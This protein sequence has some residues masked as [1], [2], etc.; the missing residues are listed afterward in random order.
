MV[1]FALLSALLAACAGC[2]PSKSAIESSIRDEMKKSMNVEVSAID[3]T[4]QPDG[5][6]TGT[7]T[8]TAGDAYDVQVSPTQGNRT[9]W[10]AVPGQAMLEKQVSTEIAKQ[11]GSQVKSFALNK[12]GFG[13][14]TGTATLANGQRMDVRTMLDGKQIRFEATPSMK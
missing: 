11:V 9:E 5:G 8:T 14:Y 3:L 12:T 7:A 1:R 13:T 10:K 4:K 6:Y 2:G